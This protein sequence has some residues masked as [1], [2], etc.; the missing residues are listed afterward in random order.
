MCHVSAVKHVWQAYGA[1]LVGSVIALPPAV[2]MV[3]GLVAWRC[4]RGLSRAIAVR[5]SV[6]EVAVVVGTAPWLFMA[7]Q[8]SA[9]GHRHVNLL[10]LHDLL[11][12]HPSA[13][14]VQIVGNLLEFAAA[15]CFLTIRFR[16]VAPI[17]RVLAAAAVCST[18]LESLQ[19]A[20]NIGRVS[21]GRHTDQRSR[22]RHRRH[23][24]VTLVETASSPVM[25]RVSRGGLALTL[26]WRETPDCWH[27][28]G[29]VVDRNVLSG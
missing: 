29:I 26:P 24:L 19:Y 21:C 12:V 4:G 8:P 23:P 6:A 27:E 13:L 18:P 2:V 1:V 7:M 20:L 15:G 3:W 25:L 16:A 14:T 9:T 17:P 28:R 22:G 5:R 11:T 10:P